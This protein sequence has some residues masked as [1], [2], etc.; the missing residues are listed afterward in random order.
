MRLPHV[1]TERCLLLLSATLGCSV[2]RLV[3]KLVR[4]AG[5]RSAQFLLGSNGLDYAAMAPRLQYYYNYRQSV[6]N[7]ACAATCPTCGGDS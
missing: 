6:S 4:H 2:T 1:L 3:V 5:G 7:C